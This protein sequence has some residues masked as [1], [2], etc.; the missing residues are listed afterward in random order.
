METENPMD[1]YLLFV[2]GNLTVEGSQDEIASALIPITKN[3]K[4]KFIYGSYHMVVNLETDLPFDELK[5]YIYETLKSDVFEYFL[6]PMSD[7]TSVKLPESMA[8]HLFD[9]ENDTDK[10]HVFTQLNVEELK[11]RD[12]QTDEELDLIIN[13][14]LSNSEFEFTS[15]DEEDEEDDLIKQVMNKPKQPSIDELLEKIVENG[16]DSLTL[17]EKQLLD[18]YSNEQR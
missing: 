12:K 3:E 18:E 16:M 15:D 17:Q 6:M 14:F 11:K 2:F 1:D 13:Y 5:E 10:V 9:L 8:E 7:K 4:V